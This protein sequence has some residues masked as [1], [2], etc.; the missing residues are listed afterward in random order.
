[1][2]SAYEGIGYVEP[3]TSTVEPVK[4]VEEVDVAARDTIPVEYVNNSPAIQLETDEY[5]PDLEY[6]LSAVVSDQNVEQRLRNE[7]DPE[8]FGYPLRGELVAVRRR[9]TDFVV[10]M[11]RNEFEF[12]FFSNLGQS[13][14]QRGRIRTT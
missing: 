4:Q 12:P 11:R 13:G 2:P 1:M 5:D 8:H 14:Q 3:K 6:E 9:R 10:H 7:L